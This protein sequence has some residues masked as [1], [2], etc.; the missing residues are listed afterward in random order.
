MVEYFHTHIL[1]FEAKI[2]IAIN[3]VSHEQMLFKKK[4]F[5][6]IVANHV[7]RVP[8]GYFLHSNDDMLGVTAMKAQLK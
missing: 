6:L 4:E 1:V 7:I 3:L 2:D 8:I 5:G